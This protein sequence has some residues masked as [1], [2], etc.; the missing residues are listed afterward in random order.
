MSEYAGAPSGKYPI[1]RLALTGSCSISMPS[2]KL[3]WSASR[4]IVDPQSLPEF[5]KTKVSDSAKQLAD[6]VRSL[7][8]NLSKLGDG[9]LQSNPLGLPVA[10]W[11]GAMDIV[12]K[13]IEAGGQV[14][15]AV[16]RGLNYIQKNHRGQWDKKGLNVFIIVV[17]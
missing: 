2:T 9:G 3:V 16:K 11:N 6:K 15:D 4:Y 13:T 14:A 8:I 12:A 17:I 7:K 1:I 10:V 5:R